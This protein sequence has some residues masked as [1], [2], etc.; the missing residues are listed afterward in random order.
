MKCEQ[1]EIKSHMMGVFMGGHGSTQV[2]GRGY[3]AMDRVCQP[4]VAS[5]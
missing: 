2:M 4:H 3:V 1:N 5:D